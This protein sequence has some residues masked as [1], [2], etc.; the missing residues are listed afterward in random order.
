MKIKAFLR[1][2]GPGIVASIIAYGI[3]Q[4]LI[5]I[6]PLI[7]FG[8]AKMFYNYGRNAYFKCD[9]YNAEKFLQSAIYQRKNYAEAHAALSQLYSIWATYSQFLGKYY[10]A[11]KYSSLSIYH[12]IKAIQ[13][14]AKG[15]EGIRALTFAFCCPKILDSSMAQ[16]LYNEGRN[17]DPNDS[18]LAYA[19]W[20]LNGKQIG[21]EIDEQP[22][23]ESISTGNEFVFAKIEYARELFLKSDNKEKEDLALSIITGVIDSH[24][25]ISLAHSVCGAIYGRRGDLNI[26]ENCFEEAI[27]FDK[28]G[29]TPYHNLGNICRIRGEFSKANKY[30]E[31]A[32]DFC[33]HRYEIYQNLGLNYIETG[34]F[35]DAIKAFESGIELNNDKPQLYAGLALSYWRIGLKELAK[36]F[37]NKAISMNEVYKT[38]AWIFKNHKISLNIAKELIA[39]W[40]TW[41]HKN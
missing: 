23:K 38:K 22:I 5:Y 29:A 20:V 6:W 11:K 27:E 15:I 10:P 12:G 18:E 3:V 16:K 36:Y 28:N 35:K 39:E 13:N 8:E 2:L 1:T 14:N 4:G 7:Y 21:S 41:E 37:L 19:L 33:K 32:R 31:V 24:K 34:K 9:F 40:Q 26:S 30:Y 25:H 17:I